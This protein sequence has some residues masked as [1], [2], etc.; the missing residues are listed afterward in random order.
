MDR[1]VL[2]PRE[3]APDPGRVDEVVAEAFGVSVE[4]LHLHGRKAGRSKGVALE[5]CCRLTGLSQ[6]QVAE[7]YGGMSCSGVTYQRRLLRKTMRADLDLADLVSRLQAR[8]LG[9][10]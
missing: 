5:L 1:D 7:H 8:L 4:D 6:R 10:N 3:L 9:K 2:W